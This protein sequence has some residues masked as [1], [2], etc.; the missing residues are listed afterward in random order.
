M[1]AAPSEAGRR[2]SRGLAELRQGSERSGASAGG[3]EVQL[4]AYLCSRKERKEVAAAA[5]IGGGG[6]ASGLAAGPGALSSLLSSPAPLRAAAAGDHEPERALDA[7]TVLAEALPEPGQAE[8]L[9]PHL[10]IALGVR[11][12][13]RSPPS[14]LLGRRRPPHSSGGAGAGYR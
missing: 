10:R 8:S 1:C 7:G 3:C 11:D 9:Q 5:A 14:R 4:L 13:E 12:G 2:L 6:G